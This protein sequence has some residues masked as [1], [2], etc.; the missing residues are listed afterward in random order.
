MKNIIDQI[1]KMRSLK[2]AFYILFLLGF[3]GMAFAQNKVS[4]DQLFENM[5]YK[6]LIKIYE[7]KGKLNAQE[8]EHVANGYRLNHD[9]E[10]AA[11]WFGEVVK[12]ECHS[13]NYLYYEIGRAHV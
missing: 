2:P 5:A 6:E 9:P 1:I 7:A 3:S 4:T 13:S 8:M 12:K 10:N 11:L